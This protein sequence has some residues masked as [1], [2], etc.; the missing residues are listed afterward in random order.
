M[1]FDTVQIQQFLQDV[2]ATHHDEGYEDAKSA[3]D[4]FKQSITQFRVLYAANPEKL[5]LLDQL[6]AKIDVFYVMGKTMAK[7]YV[8]EGIES[9][10]VMMDE[11]DE[12]AL[13][14][15][16]KM[17]ELRTNE[18]AKVSCLILKRFITNQ[19]IAAS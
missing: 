11:F 17:A 6:D 5:K 14:M 15:T 8:D 16:N 2:S 12:I 1:S 7:K 10:N 18:T 19:K 9:G 4:D 13:E 3:Y